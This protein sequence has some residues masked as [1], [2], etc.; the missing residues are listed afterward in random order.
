MLIMSVIDSYNNVYMYVNDKEYD[1]WL[2]GPDRICD[3]I[4]KFDFLI[5]F[6]RYASFSV[7]LTI[8]SFNIHEKLV[9]KY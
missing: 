3:Y 6:V 2:K 5:P 1:C 8:F 9:P 4:I 7:F